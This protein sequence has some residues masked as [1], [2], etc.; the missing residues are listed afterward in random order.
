LDL[1]FQA[2][3]RRIKAGQNPGYPR[4]KAKDRFDSWTYHL[5]KGG[6]AKLVNDK[7]RLQNIGTI[8]VKQHRLME[9]VIKT[10][11]IKREAGKWFAIFT[12][13]T[14]EIPEPHAGPPVGID[15]GLIRFLTTSDGKT[16]ANPRYLKA[17]LPTLR[18]AQRSV[19]RKK[20]GGMNRRKAVVVLQKIHARVRNVRREHHHQVAIRLVLA[21]GL[22]AV[23][24]LSIKGML[25]N[26][27]LARA[28][29]DAGWASFIGILKCKAESAGVQVVDVDPK[30]TSQECSQC[31]EHVP[32]D[33]SVRWHNCPHCGCS[34]DRDHNAARNI[35]ARARL[36]WTVPVG[37]NVGR[38]IKRPPRSRRLQATE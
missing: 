13:E 27:R 9:G 38:Q 31:Q 22:I 18:V 33:I 10:V 14:A 35:L 1:A 5:P 3:F 19:A 37:D 7:L 28:I 21:Y 29:S 23:E 8:R 17:E 36:A 30:G 25:G 12:C 15:L 6:G 32:K 34:L 16:E 4:F 11:Q 20:K 26:H 2:F 24:R